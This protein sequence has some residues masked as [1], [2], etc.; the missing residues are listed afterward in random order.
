MARTTLTPITA[1]VASQITN[2]V[3]WRFTDGCQAHRN[4]LEQVGQRTYAM[5]I[6]TGMIVVWVKQYWVQPSGPRTADIHC[7]GIANVGNPRPFTLRKMWQRKVKDSG[8]WFGH[9]DHVTIH[10][11]LH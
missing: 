3:T 8:I 7:Y 11:Y 2:N 5:K 6:S 10:D 9:P 4:L 1:L